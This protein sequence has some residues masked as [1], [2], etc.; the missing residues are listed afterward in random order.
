MKSAAS[1]W[2][3][4]MPRLRSSTRMRARLVTTIDIT[5]GGNCGHIDAVCPQRQGHRAFLH[6]TEARRIGDD[7][8]ADLLA[9]V[10][11]RHE[12]HQQARTVGVVELPQGMQGFVGRQR[13]AL[14]IK[15]GLGTVAQHGEKQVVHAREVVVH[16]RRLDPGLRGHPPGGRGGIA[17]FEHD[18]GGRSE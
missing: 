6:V 15:V 18:L 10:G 16:Q 7:L 12:L 13:L 2:P 5:T 17:L 4:V 3:R 8:A 14:A 1:A 9:V 11:Q